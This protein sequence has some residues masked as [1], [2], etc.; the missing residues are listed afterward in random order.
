MV[1][2]TMKVL[3]CTH[4]K[5]TGTSAFVELYDGASIPTLKHPSLPEVAYHSTFFSIDSEES[6]GKAGRDTPKSLRSNT[7]HSHQE[8][9]NLSIQLRNQKPLVKPLL[10]GKLD[11]HNGV[12]VGTTKTM[13]AP[14]GLM[15]P[16]PPRLATAANIPKTA[17]II[18]QSLK[19]NSESFNCASSRVP[20]AKDSA[21]CDETTY[22]KKIR[23]AL[24]IHPDEKLFI[25]AA[26]LL[27]KIG[28]VWLHLN[29][30][31]PLQWQREASSAFH[32]RR[33][34]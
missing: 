29:M 21:P 10:R 5:L 22:T 34:V 26:V 25:E 28:T 9:S 19:R 24:E 2:I 16:P 17:R 13:L 8:L 14:F 27:S 18:N 30:F 3:H 31:P 23:T 1:S 11:Y 32:R 7:D 20:I 12:M 33:E 15:L 4:A 6:A